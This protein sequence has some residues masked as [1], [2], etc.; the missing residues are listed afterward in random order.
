MQEGWVDRGSL[1][2]ELHCRLESIALVRSTDNHHVTLLSVQVLN[3]TPFNKDFLSCFF[4]LENV[5]FS[6]KQKSINAKYPL[7]VNNSYSSSVLHLFTATSAQA[8]LIFLACIVLLSFNHH[9]YKIHRLDKLFSIELPAL[10]P[11]S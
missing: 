8:D 10:S 11:S 3:A 9:P 4:I 1:Q 5:L 7:E 2:D 6:Q